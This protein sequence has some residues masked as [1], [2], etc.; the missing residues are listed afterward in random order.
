MVKFIIDHPDYFILLMACL[1]VV[2]KVLVNIVTDEKG[3][4]NNDN[5]GGSFIDEP[6]LDLPP[7]VS[8]PLKGPKETQLIN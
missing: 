4:S 5:E 3:D 7:G 2:I 1:F 6:K 8:L